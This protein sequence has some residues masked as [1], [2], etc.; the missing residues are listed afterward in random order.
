MCSGDNFETPQRMTYFDW[1]RAHTSHFLLVSI[2]LIH[3]NDGD[4]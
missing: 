3:D 2:V 4:G 1:P